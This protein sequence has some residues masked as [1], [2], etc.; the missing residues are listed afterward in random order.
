M[1]E[2]FALWQYESP[3]GERR[4]GLRREQ[5]VL[6]ELRNRPV[7]GRRRIGGGCIRRSENQFA[8]VTQNDL[9]PALESCFKPHLQTTCR[10]VKLRST[11]SRRD[12]PSEKASQTSQRRG[13]RVLSQ[14]AK[15]RLKL[16][17]RNARQQRSAFPRVAFSV[18]CSSA[19]SD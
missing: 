16:H 1:R 18:H 11:Q 17:A 4:E 6:Y 13:A 2:L 7:R 8:A 14:S 19:L 9:Y 15:A 12:W 3:R 10:V 5:D